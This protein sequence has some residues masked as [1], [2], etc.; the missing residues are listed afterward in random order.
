MKIVFTA[1]GFDPLHK[2]HLMLLERSKKLGDKFIVSVARRKHMIKK[3]GFEFMPEEQRLY[4][5]QSIKGVDEVQ[6]HMGEDGTVVENLKVL[7]ERY[8]NDEI[9]FTKGGDWNNRDIP[10]KDI[11]KELDIEIV[12]GVVGQIESSTNILNTFLEGSKE[13]ISNL[14]EEDFLNK[15]ILEKDNERYRL[16]YKEGQKLKIGMT[17]LK[18]GQETRGHSHNDIEEVYYFISGEGYIK[19]H[20]KKTPIK[21][22]E[23]YLIPESVFHKVYNTG[24]SKLSFVV[25]FNK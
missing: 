25:A 7:R 16:Y 12:D 5:I 13:A 3:K 8:P 18:E 1:G 19:I 22:G 14:M 2:G 17:V 23:V 20:D 21:A 9:I 10:E 15:G 24:S 6:Y 4:I 11:C